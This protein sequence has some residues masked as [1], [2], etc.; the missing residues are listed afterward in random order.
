MSADSHLRWEASTSDARRLETSGQKSVMRAESRPKAANHGA[1]LFDRSQ[2]DSEMLKHTTWLSP[3]HDEPVY[4]ELL[5]NESTS[6]DSA[7]TVECH[8][9]YKVVGGGCIARAAHD[10]VLDQK[11]GDVEGWRCVSG[12]N[13]A[14]MTKKVWAIC[15]LACETLS[16]DTTICDGVSDANGRHTVLDPHHMCSQSPCTA[17]M[18]C[19]TGKDC[20]SYTGTCGAAEALYGSEMNCTTTD[21]SMSDCCGPRQ[22]CQN[23]G[24]NGGTCS[25]DSGSCQVQIGAFSSFLC[26]GLECQGSECCTSPPECSSFDTV[27]AKCEDTHGSFT[28]NP[29]SKCCTGTCTCA[30]CYSST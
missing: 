15:A 16:S 21:C 18:C 24:D 3:W 30:Q 8:S 23:W 22:T 19:K 26:E 6:T 28:F 12:D 14:D 27:E 10:L 29:S 1:S 7:F 9:G 17:A 13:V 20:S 2:L 11:A 5:N 25:S 4:T